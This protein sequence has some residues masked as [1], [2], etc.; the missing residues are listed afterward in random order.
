MLIQA[1]RRKAESTHEVN[2]VR[3]KF[4]KNE[5]GD[6][7]AEVPDKEAVGRFLRIKDAFRPYGDKA[8]K[9]ASKLIKPAAQFLIANGDETMDLGELDDEQLVEFVLANEFSTVDTSLSG[10]NLRAAIV[11]A[12]KA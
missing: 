1:Y 5:N 9:E 6:F 11:A 4:A 3:F 10:D 8:I 7:V 2:G 12:T